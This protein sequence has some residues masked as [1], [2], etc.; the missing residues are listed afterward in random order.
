MHRTSLREPEEDEYL[1]LHIWSALTLGLSSGLLE[2]A[3]P[4]V[5]FDSALPQADRTRIMAFYRRCVQRHL[6][7]RHCTHKH[8]LAKNPALTPKLDSI[9]DTFPDAKIICLVRNPLDA[10]PSFVHMM[11]VSWQVVGA[12]GD[13]DALRDFVVDMTRHWYRYPLECLRH[14]T[15]DSY[16]VVKYD[17]LVADPQG[18]VTS[19]YRRFGFELSP[20]FASSLHKETARARGFASR[21]RYSLQQTGLSQQQILAKYQDVFDYFGFDT[22]GTPEPGKPPKRPARTGPQHGA[23]PPRS[24]SRSK[25]RLTPQSGA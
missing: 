21:H 22:A 18:T 5:Y 16:A 24:R 12:P 15:E 4:Y 19:L 8:Y 3:A 11:Q 9:L 2:E 13:S 17:D 6:Y 14:A 10:V 23:A 1:L 25:P 20:S 7:A